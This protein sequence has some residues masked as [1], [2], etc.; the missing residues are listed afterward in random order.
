[1]D[2]GPT[3]REL[4]RVRRVG[5]RLL[6]TQR[7]VQSLV[8]LG[9]AVTG[10]ALLDYV[11]R[12]PGVL[13]FALVVGVFVWGIVFLLTRLNRAMRF[14]PPMNLLASR[15]EKMFPSLAGL[16]AVGV[17]FTTDGR[18]ESDVSHE[19]QLA[20]MS[21]DRA[22]RAVQQVA[23][24]GS[25]PIRR[26]IDPTRTFRLTVLM[27]MA[28]VPLAVFVV[29]DPADAAMCWSRFTEPFNPSH[30]WPRKNHVESTTDAG[31]WPSDTPVRFTARVDK[32]YR[33]GLRTWVHYRVTPEGGDAT[34]QPWQRSLMN[35]QNN[36]SAGGSAGRYERIVDVLGD[37]GSGA[38]ASSDT[39]TTWSVEYYFTAGDDQ[40]LSQSLRVVPRPT[41]VGAVARTQPQ[42]YAKGFVSDQ[43]VS[44]DGAGSLA[45][46]SALRGSRVELELHFNKPL[47]AVSLSPATLAKGLPASAVAPP[48][49]RGD[50]ADH[51]T[52]SFTLD[53][54][55]QTAIDLVDAFGLKNQSDRTLRFEALTDADP[56]VAITQ[57][58]ADES[59]L[60]TAVVGIEA[61][62]Q[63][64]VAV[65]QTW[66]ESAHH[67]AGDEGNA[68][69][70]DQAP[71]ILAT[72][73]A[74]SPRTQLTH[75]LDLSTMQL[76]V[77]D[78]VVII[79]RAQ[80]GYRYQEQSHADARSQ[81]RT[82]RIIDEATLV[83]QVRT[84]LA[85]LRQQAVRMTQRQDDLTK[86]EADQAQPG[87]EQMTQQLGAQ[88][89]LIQ[90]L[91]DRL[92]RNRL[93]DPAL[94]R[95]LD[96]AK[97]LLDK[98]QVASDAADQSLK[99]SSDAQKRS[100]EQKA[101]ASRE[102]AREKQQEVGEAMTDLVSL[103][104]QGKDAAAAELELRQVQTKQQQLLAETRQMLP[105]TVGKS[106]EQL[107]PEEREALKEIEK[108]QGELSDQVESALRQMQSSA[109][110]LEK[111]DQSPESQSAAQSLREAAAI[112]QRQGLS[113][114]M[115]SSAQSAGK[116]QLSQSSVQQEQS[117][118]TLKEMLDQLQQQD[119]RRHEVL[120]RRLA[121]LKEL[122]ESL[123]AQQE[124]QIKA[125][126]GAE[127]LP[128]LEPGLSTLRRNTL[129]VEADA[130]Q[131]RETVSVA[132]LLQRA[133]GAQGDAILALRGNERAPAEAG[134]KSSLDLLEK[135]LDTV[136]QIKQASEAE[137]AQKE[138][139]ELRE[140]YLKLAEWQKTLMNDTARYGAIDN[141]TRAQ[142]AEL[143]DLGQNEEDLRKQAQQLGQKTT[144][145]EVFRLMHKQIDAQTADISD[146]L[147]QARADRDTLGQQ[148][149]VA[150]T[151]QR[152]ADA[153][154]NDP[155]R[156]EFDKP[157]ESGSGGGGG[158]GPTPLIPP[159]AELK[160]LKTSQEA[161]NTATRQTH[162]NPPDN[163][164][165][166]ASRL[167]ALS[168]AQRELAAVGE[169][170]IQKM[171]QQQ[172][173]GNS[174]NR[175]QE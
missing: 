52:I 99:Q 145:T 109:Q 9:L 14:N 159:T 116:N 5:R 33:V 85:G 103:L 106:T 79:A 158:G 95:T 57:P 28:W 128:A 22:G 121:K 23:G 46:V 87:Q 72:S 76:A 66:I 140:Q 133:A 97:G 114:N 60:R 135:A 131:A 165:N 74:A 108:R 45:S 149:N 169:R 3:I 166:A 132:D 152:M 113:Q 41:V 164:A 69:D 110:A 47:P 12:L 80:D 67:V 62:A 100:D 171:Q 90:R 120:M 39:S 2:L 130:R 136:E 156:N 155:R 53:Q 117:L 25:S 92:N 50:E 112:A 173:S 127:A 118:E 101:Q 38:T 93:A 146:R 68:P 4:E 170:L 10:M 78:S 15:T 31:V 94:Q 111:Q 96:D 30:Q 32:G 123:I 126:A 142:R 81:P 163:Q 104:D 51:V 16:L 134:E 19:A 44:L 102:Q 1:M 88:K 61:Q 21:I 64:D 65:T 82:L 40:S 36:S 122:I 35:D 70:T 125:L 75:D 91:R 56:S 139:N 157:S 148:Q 174:P 162:D 83:S 154:K 73:S 119:E 8:G 175:L 55:C 129:S 105:R 151:L 172:P 124:T 11:F 144:D 153:L 24:R 27:L 137:K 54:T 18:D 167:R 43:E 77:G 161:I 13:R 160:L 7:L 58:V 59:V 138:R 20:R 115:Q 29:A 98:A 147:R 63:D 17:E 71:L 143:A 141:L 150:D 42:E 89:P 37:T 84:E 48:S 49:S 168:D 6:V 86:Q 26:L 107:T 34:A